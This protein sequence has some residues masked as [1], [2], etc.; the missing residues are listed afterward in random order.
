MASMCAKCAE[1]D[2]KLAHYRQMATRITD[3]ATLDGI[4]GLTKELV[5]AKAALHPEERK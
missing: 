5:N 3:A 2:F 1:L 4:A